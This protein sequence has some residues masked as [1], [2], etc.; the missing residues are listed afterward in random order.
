VKGERGTE[1]TAHEVISPSAFVNMFTC[2]LKAALASRRAIAEGRV[3]TLASRR[4]LNKPCEI[5]KR[6]LI[7]VA[8]TVS[9]FNPSNRMLSRRAVSSM[10]LLRCG[11][12][13]QSRRPSAVA[14]SDAPEG[15]S[16]ARASTPPTV[17]RIQVAIGQEYESGPRMLCHQLLSN[18]SF[19]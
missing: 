9:E 7:T 16:A 13:C 11:Y 3:S 14:S 6:S 2:I 10:I 18:K 19:R 8:G 12:D 4:E 1:L 15:C 5:D 17:P